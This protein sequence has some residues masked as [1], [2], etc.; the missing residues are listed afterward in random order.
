M[1]KALFY[2]AISLMALFIN[3]IVDKASSMCIYHEKKCGGWEGLWLMK[4]ALYVVALSL[5]F[6]QVLIFNW[7]MIIY[8]SIPSWVCRGLTN[9][10]AFEPSSEPHKTPK[11]I[12][13]IFGVFLSKSSMLY[14]VQ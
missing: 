10:I 5:R 9:G 7:W 11:K 14:T 2:V 12:F 4:L 3:S 13:S 1:L 6:D 8:N